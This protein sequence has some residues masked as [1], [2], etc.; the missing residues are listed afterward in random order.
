MTETSKKTFRVVAGV[1]VRDGKYLI[2]QRMSHAVLADLWEFPGGK[3]EEGESN[4]VALARELEYRIGVSASVGELI[5]ETH[6]DYD[7]YQVLLTLYECEIG[8]QQPV[9]L[10]V[11]D[12]SWS[13]IEDMSNYEFAPADKESMDKLVLAQPDE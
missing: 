3:L 13:S 7:D 10:T 2:T 1:I 6:R 8:S 11:Q 4:Q 12:I 5:S 9:P